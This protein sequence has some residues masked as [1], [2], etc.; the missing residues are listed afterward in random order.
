MAWVKW[1]AM[2][3]LLL[4][5]WALAE[6]QQYYQADPAKLAALQ[7]ARCANLQKEAELIRKRLTG[8]VNLA[9]DMERMKT[10]LRA[11]EASAVKYCPA[12]STVASA[13]VK[14]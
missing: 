13:P 8:P 1:G 6:Q 10:K 11:V 7:A 9:G 12:A 5:G 14:R 2:T 4:S 3:V